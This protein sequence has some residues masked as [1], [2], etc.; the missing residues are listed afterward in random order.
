M[1]VGVQPLSP[2]YWSGDMDIPLFFHFLTRNVNDTRDLYNVSIHHQD[3]C[4]IE[5]EELR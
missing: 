5:T 3:R 4:T 1:G 2:R